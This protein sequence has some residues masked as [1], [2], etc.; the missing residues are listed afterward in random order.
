MLTGSCLSSQPCSVCILLSVKLIPN[1]VSEVCKDVSI[2]VS[3]QKTFWKGKQ[4]PH[5]GSG[6][7]NEVTGQL[8][9]SGVLA[10]GSGVSEGL[11]SRRGTSLQHEFR[12]AGFP[13]CAKGAGISDVTEEPSHS[14]QAGC[15]CCFPSSES[16]VSGQVSTRVC[17]KPDGKYF[18]LSSPCPWC[19]PGTH[20]G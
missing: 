11:W 8:C 19:L 3:S 7:R 5:P 15:A 4:T 18:H 17:Q 12:R 9:C 6:R 2:P 1:R 14:R 13:L 20:S 16:V 10:R